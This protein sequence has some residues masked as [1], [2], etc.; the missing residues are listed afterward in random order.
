MTKL[1]TFQLPISEVDQR[2]LANFIQG[3][4]IPVSLHPECKISGH[5]KRALLPKIK[6][7]LAVGCGMWFT[8]KESAHSHIQVAHSHSGL[9]CPW[10]GLDGCF[11]F[12]DLF[13]NW[14]A[15]C[16]HL[17]SVQST[18]LSLTYGHEPVEGN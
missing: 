18:G 5:Q 14:E 8:S 7:C 6:N 16:K 3:Q 1:F 4:D 17:D 13:Q 9:F 12:R 2:H 15:F 11:Q 10:A